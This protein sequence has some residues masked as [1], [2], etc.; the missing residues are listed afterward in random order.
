MECSLIQWRL[1]YI[2]PSFKQVAEGTFFKKFPVAD[3]YPQFLG[4]PIK[5][6]SEAAKKFF[7]KWP[8]N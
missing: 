8:G 7:S 4:R 3:L 2:Y 6:V 5:Y 1:Y